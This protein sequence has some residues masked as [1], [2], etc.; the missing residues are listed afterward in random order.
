MNFNIKSCVLSTK[1]SNE[2]FF[3]NFLDSWTHGLVL[4]PDEICISNKV[5]T[6]TSVIWYALYYNA[7]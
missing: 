1:F 5:I 7:A 3:N 6:R 4:K 2:F